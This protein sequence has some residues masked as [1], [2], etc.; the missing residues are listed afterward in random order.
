MKFIDNFKMFTVKRDQHV[1]QLYYLDT[2]ESFN[3]PVISEEAKSYSEISIV[4]KAIKVALEDKIVTATIS[5]QQILELKPLG[6]NAIEITRSALEETWDREYQIDLFNKVFGK[7]KQIESELNFTGIEKWFYHLIGYKPKMYAS[8]PNF[9][10]KILFS[11]NL[12]LHETRIS[13]GDWALVSPKLA[14]I[15]YDDPS[16]VHAQN[17][18]INDVKIEPISFIGTWKNIKIYSSILIDNHVLIGRS[19]KNEHDITIGIVTSDPVITTSKVV[20]LNLE[21]L[22]LLEYK[23]YCSIYD[24]PGSEKNYV[25]FDFVYKKETFSDFI[26]AKISN[27]FSMYINILKNIFK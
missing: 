8:N 9:L 14:V 18:G 21:E 5:N 13:K 23:K 3:Q 7:A 4:P 10:N 25:K 15:F 24:I 17:N 2:V 27:M 12:I 11:S 6:I 16:F 26:K 19:P 20:Q 22:H 1:A